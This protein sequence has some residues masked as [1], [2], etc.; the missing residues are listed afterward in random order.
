MLPPSTNLISLFSV[1]VTSVPSPS[2]ITNPL[3]MSTVSEL[4]IAPVA[5][6]KYPHCVADIVVELM[7]S[8]WAPSEAV[9]LEI[10]VTWDAAIVLFVKVWLA[11]NWT[12][13]LFVML[14]ILVAVAALPVVD[15]ELPD[16]LPVTL[17]VKCALTVPLVAI[18][19]APVPG[20][21]VARPTWNTGVPTP[22]LA[23]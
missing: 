4:V 3:P 23:S 2:S 12:I 1:I 13:L 21:V 14:D 16:T 6:P 18:V 20:S 7:F 19:A 11:V 8:I 9:I 22:E 15:P 10:S 17:P 5:A